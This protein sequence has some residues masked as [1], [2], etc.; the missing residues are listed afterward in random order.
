M[1]SPVSPGSEVANTRVRIP[2]RV[3]AGSRIEGEVPPGSVVE[4]SGQRVV[5]DEHGRVVLQAPEQAGHWNVHVQ[6]PGRS[7]P[8]MLQVTVTEVR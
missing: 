5:A 6:R 7:T 3:Q 4:A 8:L 2:L 1:P